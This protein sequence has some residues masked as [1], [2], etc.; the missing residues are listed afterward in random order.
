MAG[1]LS[2]MPR[3]RMDLIHFVT[4]AM[5][6]ITGSVRLPVAVNCDWWCVQGCDVCYTKD[7]RFVADCIETPVL[8]AN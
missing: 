4:A 7:G 5:G 1:H 8:R 3:H 2:K 6:Q